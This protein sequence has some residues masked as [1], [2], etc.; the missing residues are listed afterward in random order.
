MNN[1]SVGTPGASQGVP[2]S[3]IIPLDQLRSI[4]LTLAGFES[5]LSPLDQLAEKELELYICHRNRRNAGIRP[6]PA[7]VFAADPAVV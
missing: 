5:P 1:R 7:G 4:S 3:S 6:G 2:S